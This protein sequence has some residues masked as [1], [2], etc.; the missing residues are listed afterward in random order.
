M[1]QRRTGDR[2]A[3]DA[4]GFDGDGFD[5][6]RSTFHGPVTGKIAYYHE[7]SRPPASWPHQVGAIPAQAGGFQDRAET[8]LLDRALLLTGVTGVTHATPTAVLAGLGGTGKT[9]LAARYART[10]WQSGDL[11]VLVWVTAAETSAVISSYAAAAT[12]LLGSTSP[13][14]ADQAATAFLAWLEPKF[15]QRPCRWLVVLDDVTDPDHL[16]GLWP[17]A[18]PTG[19]TLVTTRSREPALLAGRQ[20]IPV[21]VFSPAESLAYLNAVLAAHCLAEPQEVV[22]ALAHDLGHL[23][24][25]LSQAAAYVAELSDVGMNCAQYRRLFSD[26]ATVLDDTAPARRPD[27]QRETVAAT[28]ALS[29]E[30]ADA[31]RPVGFARPLLQLAAFLDGNGVPDAVL[32]S[33][34]ARAYVTRNRS[35]SHS[36]APADKAHASTPAEPT[37]RPSAAHTTADGL[38]SERDVRL[39]L[40]ILRRLSLI[41]RPPEAV[42]A[43]VRVHQIVQRAVRDSLTGPQ[44]DDAARAAA[45]ALATTWPYVERDTSLARLLRDNTAALASCAEDALY[46]PGAHAVL[47]RAGRSLGKSGQVAAARDYHRRLVTSTTKRLG[48]DHP[49][50]LTA[51]HGLARWTGQCGEAVRATAIFSALL[52]D[53]VRV[54]GSDHP[55]TLGARHHLAYSCGQAGDAPAA[56]AAF[57]GLLEDRTRVLGPDHPHTLD[58][59]S[60]LARWRGEAGDAPA[61]AAAFAELLEDRTRILGPHHPHTLSTRANL[62]YAWGQMGDAVKASTAFSELLDDMVQVLGPEHPSTLI[63]RETLAEWQGEAGD[64]AGAVAALTGVVED[65]TRVLGAD[66]PLSTTSRKTLAHW[67]TREESGPRSSGLPRRGWKNLMIFVALRLIRHSPAPERRS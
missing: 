64:P 11:D 33:A 31:L 58:T 16:C 19:C 56:A 46:R 43:E 22:A 55:D 51:R 50:T 36:T 49:N 9:Q 28:W 53:M 21:G 57:A 14:N 59:R 25:A 62:A 10:L 66:H 60:N 44:R 45:D 1:E 23:P 54:L 47:F 52:D 24:L 5:F 17:P 4:A 18:S 13:V 40:S 12:E 35:A 15:G 2:T 37:A 34:P 63:T 29:I 8:V 67:R 41:D 7:P 38:L 6:R 48:P 65:M 61:A 32:V 27:G 42:A 39:S 20:L 3:Q 26:R 30:R